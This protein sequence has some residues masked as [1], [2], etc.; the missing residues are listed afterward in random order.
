MVNILL[1]AVLAFSLSACA[2][3]P[4]TPLTATASSQTAGFATLALWGTWE[5]ELAPAYTRL[6]A[7]R[8]RA[9]R[10]LQDGRIPVATAVEIQAAADE[11]RSKLDASRR[12]HA[13]AP[14]AEQRALLAEARYA[15][16]QAERLLEIPR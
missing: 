6:A 14:T 4:P 2:T 16:Y 10:A 7:L 12:G 9:A 15:L 13:A 11:A 5:S 8:H 1:V 3:S